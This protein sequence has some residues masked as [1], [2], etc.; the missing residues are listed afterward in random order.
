[1]IITGLEM[2]QFDIATWT[3]MRHHM[4]RHHMGAHNVVGGTVR[5]INR[6]EVDYIEFVAEFDSSTWTGRQCLS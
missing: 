4:E 3:A 6:F 1:M 2:M 5:V